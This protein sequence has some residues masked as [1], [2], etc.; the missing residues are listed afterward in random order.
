MCLYS[1]SK[2]RHPP[3]GA[4]LTSVN[5]S[6][7]IIAVFGLALAFERVR[8]TDPRDGPGFRPVAIEPPRSIAGE[9]DDEVIVDIARTHPSLTDP[10]IT[11]SSK[12]PWKPF[13]R[14]HD[15]M[16]R[17]QVRRR[18]TMSEWLNDGVVARNHS[19]RTPH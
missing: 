9:F 19:A 6:L 3:A 14:P 18:H 11:S 2:H 13:G 1:N 4:L 8:A 17:A 7:F 10:D 5:F 16:T 12:I 15:L